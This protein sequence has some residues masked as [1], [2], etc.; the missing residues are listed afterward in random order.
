M[1][2]EQVY[3]ALCVMNVLLR[4]L[5]PNT[6]WPAKVREL[7]EGSFAKLELRDPAELGCPEGWQQHP[8]WN[9]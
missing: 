7:V 1:Q 8:I 3:G 2:S 6:S 5:S 9:A 4:K